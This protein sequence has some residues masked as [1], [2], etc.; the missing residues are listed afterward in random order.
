[1]AS[2][3]DGLAASDVD[4]RGYGLPRADGLLVSCW[5]RACLEGAEVLAGVGRWER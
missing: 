5:R 4:A 3:A 2:R 1:V